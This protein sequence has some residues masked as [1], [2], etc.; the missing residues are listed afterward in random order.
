MS[1]LRKDEQVEPL[2]DGTPKL[3]DPGAGGWAPEPKVTTAELLL[4][5][6]HAGIVRLLGQAAVDAGNAYSLACQRDQSAT[7]FEAE[8][9]DFLEASIGSTWSLY[10]QARST[11]RKVAEESIAAR[12]T[13]LDEKESSALTSGLG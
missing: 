6:N 4:Y 10:K 7:G 1:P 13:L 9:G 8:S 12:R 2:S 11:H 5:G 3:I